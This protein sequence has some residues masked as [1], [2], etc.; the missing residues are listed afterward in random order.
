M[1]AMGD[2]LGT[3]LLRGVFILDIDLF[4]YIGLNIS[5]NTSHGLI[6]LLH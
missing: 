1:K 4:L 2:G 3:W 5:S 6:L